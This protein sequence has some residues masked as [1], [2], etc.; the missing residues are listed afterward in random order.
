MYNFYDGDD[1]KTKGRTQNLEREKPNMKFIKIY[2]NCH[3]VYKYTRFRYK[4]YT[5]V[6]VY[7]GICM[8]VNVYVRLSRERG[9]L[10]NF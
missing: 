9:K 8:Y 7:Y 1:D 3:A 6:Y 4:M 5:T 10:F 2:F